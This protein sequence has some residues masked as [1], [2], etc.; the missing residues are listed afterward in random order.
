MNLEETHKLLTIIRAAY[1]N[2]YKSSDFDETAFM[3]QRGLWHSTFKDCT[4]QEVFTAFN[5]WLATEPFPPTLAH[6]NKLIKKARTPEAF[7]SAELAWEQVGNAIRKYGWV[8]QEK[9]MNS[10]AP[11]IQRAIQYIGGWQ[12]LC[13]ATDKEWDFKRKDFLDVYEEF[14]GE[15]QKQELLPT[16]ILHRLQDS[17]E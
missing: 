2:I 4:Y 17:R 7:V 15:S 14:E 10:F 16:S 11:N 5:T 3:I 6:L 13:S 9:A 1:P 8:N 12:R